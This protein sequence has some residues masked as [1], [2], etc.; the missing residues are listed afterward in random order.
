MTFLDTT[1][2]SLTASNFN[3]PGSLDVG[4][5]IIVNAV[6]T[7]RV[8]IAGTATE[9]QVLTAQTTTIADADGLGTFSYQWLR[10]GSEI[11]G[12]TGA[13]Y[14]LRQID[15]DNQMSVRVSYTDQNGFLET[16]TSA[17][18]SDVANVDDAPTGGVTI[19]GTARKGQTL[20][21]ASTVADEDGIDTQSFV[22]LR[23][24]TV[25]A[26]ATGASYTL[27][28]ADIGTKVAAALVYTDDYGNTARVTSAASGTVASL[29]VV[30]PPVVTPPVVT[31]PVVTPPVVT[32]P[33][34]TP[35]GPTSGDDDLTGTG[36]SDSISGGGGSDDLSGGGGSD[37]LFGGSGGDDLFGGSGGDDL[38]GGAGKDDLFGGGGKDK[39]YGGGAADTLKGGGSK[40]MLYGGGSK[41]ML[42]GDGGKDA[43]YGGGGGDKLYGGNGND[44]LSGGGGKDMLFGGAGKDKLEGGAAKNILTSGKGADDFIF[45]DGDTRTAKSKRDVITDFGKGDDIDLRQMDADTGDKRDDAFTFNGQ[46]AADHAVWYEVKGDNVMVMGDTDG[47]ARA[48]FMIELLDV[49]SLTA[50]DFLL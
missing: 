21:A 37:D 22:W 25:I 45:D 44:A 4:A 47:D 11:A 19:S 34:V 36:G 48:D 33:V 5:P 26:N 18:T 43:L 39:L 27:T 9:D 8:T 35:K 46:T 14:T 42:Y 50:R 41:D 15:V 17:V 23:N 30:T 2:T 16:F 31:P 10:D 13:S 20:T 3:L 40:D 28:T 1:A 7:G 29:P 32:P 38:F 49:D 12:A 24:G 6:P